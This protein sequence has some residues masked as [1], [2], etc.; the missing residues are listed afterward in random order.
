MVNVKPSAFG[1]VIWNWK[2]GQKFQFFVQKQPGTRPDTTD[3]RYYIYDHAN[4]RWLHSAT[5]TSPN[6]GKKSV[7]TIGG[8]MNSFLENFAGKDRNFP[9]I[10]LY[11]L[12]LGGNISSMKFLTRSGGDGIWG[13]LHDAYFLAEGDTAEL[14]AVFDKLEKEYGKPAFGKKGEKLEPIPDQPMP[15][16]VAEALQ[17]LPRAGKVKDSKS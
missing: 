1:L 16:K 4:K 11:H 6:G 9:K 3:T 12:W 2:L 17:N 10:A 5:I 13:Q 7:T 8:G 14:K 15:P